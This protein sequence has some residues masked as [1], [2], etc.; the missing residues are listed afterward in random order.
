VGVKDLP[1][2]P[3]RF[4][5]VRPEELAGLRRDPDWCDAART[6]GEPPR[7]FRLRT[8]RRA[9]AKAKRAKL[10]AARYAARWEQ[11]HLRGGK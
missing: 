11:A 1:T 7:W 3:L 10:R 8:K 2:A 9:K 4:L 6:T 5:F